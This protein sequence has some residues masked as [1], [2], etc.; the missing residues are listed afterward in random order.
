MDQTALF[1]ARAASPVVPASAIMGLTIGQKEWR[2]PSL[3]SFI[4][5][6]HAVARFGN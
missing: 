5:H 1:T 6:R 3:A 2:Q 4:V